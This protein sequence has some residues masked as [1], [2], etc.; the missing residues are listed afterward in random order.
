MH[1]DSVIVIALSCFIIS[2]IPNHTEPI[3]LLSHPM[4]EVEGL[5]VRVFSAV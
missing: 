2:F 3:C 5:M 4:V 1:I